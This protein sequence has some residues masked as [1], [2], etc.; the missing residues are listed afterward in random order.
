MTELIMTDG[1]KVTG[2]GEVEEDENGRVMGRGVLE[3]MM[4]MW[5]RDGDDVLMWQVMWPI[6]VTWQLM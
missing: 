6:K 1:E 2:F 5:Q 3:K 4:M